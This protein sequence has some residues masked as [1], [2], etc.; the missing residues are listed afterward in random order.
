MNDVWT[1]I[2]M[3]F[4]AILVTGNIYF[5]SFPSDH[6]LPIRKGHLILSKTYTLN[7]LEFFLLSARWNMLKP[8]MQKMH[9]NKKWKS[10]KYLFLWVFGGFDLFCLARMM[11]FLT[12]KLAVLRIQEM[13]DMR[14]QHYEWSSYPRRTHRASMSTSSSS[15]SCDLNLNNTVLW[16]NEYWDCWSWNNF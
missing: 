10:G 13:T 2:G 14:S 7:W 5:L 8:I 11:S 3:N 12:E 6:T 1:G 15:R 4:L 16:V 9:C